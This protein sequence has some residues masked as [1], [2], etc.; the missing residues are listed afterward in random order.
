MKE[1]KAY[2]RR[3]LAEDVTK[4]LRNGGAP[5]LTA[6]DVEGLADEVAGEDR[7]ISSELAS[8]YSAMVKLELICEDEDVHRFVE[9]IRKAAF[10][11]RRGDGII[12]VSSLDGVWGIRTGEQTC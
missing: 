6:I 3:F 11:G 5:R 12:A 10:T 2:V 9:E 8:T 4:A 7:Q 1:I